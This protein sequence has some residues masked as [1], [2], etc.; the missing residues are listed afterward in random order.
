M[1]NYQ[2]VYHNIVWSI[3]RKANTLSKLITES[4]AHIHF[5]TFSINYLTAC[6]PHLLIGSPMSPTSVPQSQFHLISYVIFF[7]YTIFL[8]L[9]SIRSLLIFPHSF[10]QELVRIR[11][12][13]KPLTEF[14]LHSVCVF[15]FML[16]V[17]FQYL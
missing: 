12:F 15:L 1:L 14:W 5:C 10:T 11:A 7:Q 8:S 17:G 4:I 13:I 16:F 3:Y 2:K 9:L 6:R